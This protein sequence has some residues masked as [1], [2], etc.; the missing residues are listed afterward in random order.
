M[1]AKDVTSRFD[2]RTDEMYEHIA[3]YIYRTVKTKTGNYMVFFPSFEFADR[4]YTVLNRKYAPVV[5]DILRQSENM[6]EPEREAFL[7]KFR[8]TAETEKKPA[9]SKGFGQFRRSV[10]GFCVLG[11][12]FA[13]GIDLVG[14]DLIGAIIVGG[15]IPFI[16]KDR[17]LIREYFDE[18]EGKGYE[19]A[20]QIPGMNKV[21]QAAGRVIRNQTDKGTVLYLERRFLKPEYE[22]VFPPHMKADEEVSLKTLPNFMAAFWKSVE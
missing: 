5:F 15:G 18:K 20:Y 22:G 21:L 16:T 2:D 19:F 1:V 9:L 14:E 13:E 6:S 17:E 8:K 11:G 10:V 12:I 3:G 7:A 4:V